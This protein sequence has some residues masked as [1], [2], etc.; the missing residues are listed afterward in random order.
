[1]KKSISILIFFL[2]LFAC[3][4][5][6]FPS[7]KKFSTEINFDVSEWILEGRNITC[8]DFD[9]DGNAWIASGSEL[10]FYDGNKLKTHEVGSAIL[11]LAVA[12]NGDVWLGTREMGL[13]RFSNGNFE[14][15]TEKNAGLPRN[16]THNVEVTSDGKVWFC[17]AGHDLGGLMCF[18][19]RKFELFSPENSIINQ[20]VIQNLEVDTHDNVYL[21]TSGKVGKATVFKIDGNNNIEQLGIDASFY[22]ISSLAVTSNKQVYIETDHSLSSCYGCFEDE[23]LLFNLGNWEKIETNFN[24]YNQIFI[25]KRDFIWTMGEVD[26][27]HYSLFVF[28]GDEW[29]RS[30]KGQIPE[31]YI[32]S[33]KVDNQNN[34]WFCTEEGIFILNQ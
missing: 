31:I 12:P 8:V 26:R 3:E 7:E 10:I 25:D 30:A 22:W 5:D 4:K 9:K 2:I 13:A 19:G 16:Y 33:V 32:K 34:I 21:N 23:I 15:Y 1:M 18:D 14:Y 17:S 11:D 28:D 27:D 24:F 6:E 29:Q 20:H